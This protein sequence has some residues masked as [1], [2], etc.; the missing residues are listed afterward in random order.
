MTAYTSPVLA[1]SAI[2]ELAV[3]S[4]NATHREE[5]EL[6]NALGALLASGLRGQVAEADISAKLDAW[7]QHTRQHFERENQLMQDYG[8][9]ALPV[10]RG[11]HARML[12]IIESQQRQWL[13]SREVA[14]LAAFVF[15]QWPDWFNL[16]VNTMD[17]VTAAFISHRVA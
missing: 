12:G 8:F 7:V 11:E 3:E 4:M 1:P 15:R 16:H 5:V 14:P 10:H 17:R 6:V 9:P 2:P 13:E